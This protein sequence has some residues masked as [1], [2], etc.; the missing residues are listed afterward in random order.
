MNKI[1]SFENIFSF[2]PL[3]YWKKVEGEKNKQICS[4]GKNNE[5]CAE[6]T[7]LIF[8]RNS[9]HIYQYPIDLLFVNY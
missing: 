2:Y 5:Y 4:K 8:F 3:P 1:K 9:F 7:N 6:Y